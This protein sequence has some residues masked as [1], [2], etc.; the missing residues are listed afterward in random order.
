MKFH[1][2]E[3]RF[4]SPAIPSQINSCPAHILQHNNRKCL[5]VFTVLFKYTLSL[6][7]ALFTKW[8]GEG[9]R[10]EARTDKGGERMTGKRGG[11]D[12]G[13][14]ACWSFLS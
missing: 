9:W 14:M 10:C 6:F 13:E 3:S 4:P 5:F 8:G 12:A 11:D 2:K 1:L 7:I